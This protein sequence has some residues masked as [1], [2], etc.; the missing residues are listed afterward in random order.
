MAKLSPVVFELYQKDMDRA[1]NRELYEA[2]QLLTKRQAAG[3]PIFT[4]KKKLY[5]LSAEFLVGRLLG[6]NLLRLGLYQTLSEEL[7]AAGKSL[8][9]LE[10]LEPEPSLGNGGLGRLA[11][12]YLDSVA[13]LGLPGDGIGLA[14][15]LGLFRQKFI[16]HK[17]AETPNPWIEKNSWLAKEPARFQVA[18]GRFTIQAALY[19]IA[20]IGEKGVNRLRLFDAETVDE[21]IVG[22]GIAFD[23]SDIQKNLTLFLYPDDSTDAGRLLR[24]YQQYFLVSCAAQLILQEMEEAGHPLRALDQHAAIQINDTHPSM[25]IPELIRLLM[26]KGIAF[27]NAAD[28]VSKTCA[29]TNHT[30]LAEALEK[31]PVSFLEQVAPQIMPIIEKLDARARGK[32]PADGTEIIDEYGLVHMARLCIHYGH[33]VNGVAALHTKILKESE[34]APFYRIYPEKFQNITNGISFKRWLTHAN[35]ALDQYLVSLIGDGFHQNPDELVHLLDYREDDAALF[36]LSRIKRAN[37]QSLSEYLFK[38]Q[39]VRLDADAVF[40]IQIKR[41]HQYKRQQMNALYIIYKYL[42]VKAGRLP[43]RPIAALFGGKAAPA[44]ILA[45]D[46][47]HLILCLSRLIAGDPAVSPWLQVVMV[48]NY[49]VTQAEKL[50]PAADISEQISLASKEASGTG[51][52][53]LMLNGAVTLGTLDGA[54]VEIHDLVGD[55][56]MYLFG[57]PSDVVIDLYKPGGYHPSE[58]YP[59]D[60]LIERLVD[61][62]IG[63]ELRAI[64]DFDS[65]WRLYK[66]FISKDY[67]MALPDT[68][69]Y[70]ETKERMLSDYEDPRAWRQKSLA[71]T[72]MAGFFSSDRAVR[73][74]NEKIWGLG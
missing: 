71:N 7:S 23:P 55:T 32:F 64:G 33:C 61:F 9:E 66:D 56:N 73:Q 65:L 27:D 14:Y 58:F 39:N 30:I 50:I 21:R 12:C 28:I 15:H 10:A 6:N 3:L 1:S 2:L 13:S 5:Y 53:K 70:I 74:Y 40:D 72:A 26:D 8:S 34:L 35:P 44:Y 41:L 69:G 42:E 36:A 51:N 63:P 48:E 47:I 60:P 25:I 59:C 17:Q 24:V 46:V 18:F 29:Y 37:K 67:F 19:S 45:K 68:R 54:N 16:N 52:M 4:G 57:Q 43:A 38:S 11:A 20:V 22:E 31:W 62:I 49:N